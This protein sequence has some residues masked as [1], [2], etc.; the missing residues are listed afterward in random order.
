MQV[1]AGDRIFEKF[2]F[3]RSRNTFRLGLIDSKTSVCHQVNENLK[4]AK[5]TNT[6]FTLAKILSSL[7]SIV[8]L[9]LHYTEAYADVRIENTF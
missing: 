1:P 6:S 7:I 2:P 5:L 4:Q 8:H 9:M 3:N